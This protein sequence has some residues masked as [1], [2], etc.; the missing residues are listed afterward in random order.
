ME[1]SIMVWLFIGRM[2]VLAALYLFIWSLLRV[3]SV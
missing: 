1:D 2:V 3:A